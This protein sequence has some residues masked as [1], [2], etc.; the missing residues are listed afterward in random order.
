MLQLARSS[1][2]VVVPNDTNVLPFSAMP[3]LKGSIRNILDYAYTKGSFFDVATERFKRYGPI[4]SEKILGTQIV[5]ISDVE[6]TIKVLRTEK[7]FQMR[8]GFEALEDVGDEINP[9]A[10]DDFVKRMQRLSERDETISN[11]EE[12][13]PYCTVEAMFNKRLGFDDHPQNPDAVAYVE[14]AN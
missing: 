10:A 1:S 14:S 8:P 5:N 12:E 9:G 11:L 6:A 3:G 7:S 4:Y 13:L 2:T